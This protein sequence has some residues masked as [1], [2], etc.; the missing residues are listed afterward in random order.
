MLLSE[1]DHAAV[2][3]AV[4]QAELSTD[5]E[6]V[7][8]VA[9]RSDAYHDVALHWAVLAMLLALALLAWQPWPAEWLYARL[10]DGWAE[11]VPPGWYLTVALIV[12]AAK[13]L[14]VRLLLAI[15][16]LRLFLTP[17]TTKARR[18]R[19]RAVELFRTGAE[20]RTKASTGV[21]LYLS[22]AERRAEIIADESIHS[23]VA[24]D[25]WGAAMAALLAKVRA[26]QPGEGMAD[27]VARIGLVLAEHFPR[28]Q[29]DTNEL[30]DRLIE[31]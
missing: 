14:G 26:G 5:G 3:A 18:V 2:T 16:A 31:L 8:V 28:S 27:A 12:A 6:I 15:D 29:G 4:T 11:S 21:L 20:K 19:R 24:P 30:P 25:V 22:L 23:K 17:G 9:A 10:V 13:F 1:A 7:T